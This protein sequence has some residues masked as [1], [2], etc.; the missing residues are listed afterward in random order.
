MSRPPTSQSE[1]VDSSSRGEPK[2]DEEA[3]PPDMGIGVDQDKKKPKEE[4][5]LE[6]KG[7]VCP[8]EYVNDY[9]PMEF[10]E[11]V[12]QFIK[13]DID[14]SHSLDKFELQKLLHDMVSYCS[15]RNT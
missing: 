7:Y 11:L 8:Q 5:T 4:H 6:Y 1:K 15:F 9:T 12:E 2:K 3:N 10:E 14:E 13:Y